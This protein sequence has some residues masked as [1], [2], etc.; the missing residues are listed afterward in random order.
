MNGFTVSVSGAK[1]TAKEQVNRQ[2][3]DSELAQA[4]CTLIDKAPGDQVSLSGSLY[5]AEDGLSG[6]ISIS[7]SFWSKSTT[8]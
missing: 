4:L 8:A 7:G 1:G 2:V 6:S 5:A 3:G